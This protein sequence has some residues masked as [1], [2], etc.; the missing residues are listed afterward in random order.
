MNRIFIYPIARD[1]GFAPNPFHGVCTLA[2]CKPRIRKAA[3]P[4]DWVVGMGGT[5]LKAT[6]R[7]IFA[8]RVEKCLSFNEYWS[9]PEYIRKRPIRNGSRKT[10]VGDNIYHRIPADGVWQQADSHHSLPDG[11]PNISNIR[12]DTSLRYS[13]PLKGAKKPFPPETRI[14]G[15]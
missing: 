8:M 7:C 15:Y 3:A 2:T 12:T 5:K 6:G 10:M 9:D 1:F 14:H 13:I 11:K 4:G